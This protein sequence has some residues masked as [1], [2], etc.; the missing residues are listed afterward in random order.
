MGERLRHLVPTRLGYVHAIEAGPPAGLPIVLLHQTPR[1][2]DEFAEVLPLLARSRRTIAIDTPGYGCSDA[3]AGQPTIADYAAAIVDVWDRLGIPSAWVVGHHTGAVVAVEL[4]AAFPGR[5]AG[6]VLSGPV[7]VDAAGRDELTRHF[8]QWRT[9]ADGSH[10]LEKWEKFSAWVPNPPLVQRLVVD[11]FRAG[12][13][14]EQGHF[15]VAAY[16]MEDRLPLVRCPGLLVYGRRDPFA[17]PA[18]AGLF[19]AVLRPSDAIVLDAGVF[20]PNEA[21][22][23]LADAVRTF[24]DRVSSSSRDA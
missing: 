19:R 5:V 22:A 3:V 23:A 2:T 15:A 10:L 18:Q 13:T 4:A 24:I 11:L 8:V 9:R 14:S 16:R 6:L 20:L 7:Y 12:E 1:S 21:P 17:D